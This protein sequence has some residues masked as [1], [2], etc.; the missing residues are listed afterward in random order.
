MSNYELPTASAD[1]LGGVKVGTGL[2][3]AD[4]VLSA[5]GGGKADSVDW[6][7]IENKPSDYKPS[8]HTHV[9]S[10]VSDLSEVATSGSYNDLTD[11][12]SIPTNTNQL[13]NGAG[14]Q[15]AA[16]VAAAVANANHLKRQ[17]VDALPSAAEADTNTIYMVKLSQGGEQNSYVEYMVVNG[18]WEKLGTSDVD[19]SNYVTNDD[20]TSITNGEI[21]GIAV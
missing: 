11:K 20:L 19:L 12:P 3:I 16:E 5:T 13:V 15:T 8:P 17:I 14:F 9:A 21:D 4:G 6:Q 2:E 18:Q 7:D 1:T 10:D